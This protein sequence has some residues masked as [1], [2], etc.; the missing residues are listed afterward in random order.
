MTDETPFCVV[1]FDSTSEALLAEK[2]FKKAGI[3]HKVI[4]VPRH[5]SSDCGVCIRFSDPDT[6]RV[7]AALDGRVAVRDI[8]PLD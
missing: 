1:L 7:R 4:P 8:S 3:P 6:Q 5:I 2:L